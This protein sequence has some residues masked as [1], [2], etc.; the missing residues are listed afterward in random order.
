MRASFIRLLLPALLS[1]APVATAAADCFTSDDYAGSPKVIYDCS[2]WGI[3]WEVDTWTFTN[4]GGGN[5]SV[6]PNPATFPTLTGTIDCNDSTF[7]ASSFQSGLCL[8]SYT[9][10][11]KFISANTWTG[12]FSVWYGGYCTECTAHDYPVEG[13]LGTVSVGAIARPELSLR[14]GPNPARDG[15]VISLG[16]SRTSGVVVEVL[17]VG[18]RRVG[19]LQNGTLDAGTHEFRWDRLTAAG[20][21]PAGVYLVRARAGAE[22]RVVRIAAID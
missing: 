9:L 20:R 4:D 13:S 18:G 10:T 3:A 6:D 22:Q 7:F 17:D 12:T 11:G 5:I 14:A 8:E 1:V 2:T 16:L 19:L 15:A 21:A